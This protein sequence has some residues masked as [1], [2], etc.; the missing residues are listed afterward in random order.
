MTRA[1]AGFTLVELL[2]TLTVVAILSAIAWPG[3]GAI[4]HRAQR[5]D[6]RFALL[7]LQ[8]LQER[9]YATHFR[10][11]SAMGSTAANDTL[12]TSGTS[13]GGLYQLS[14]SVTEDGQGYVAIASADPDGRQRRD[15]DC[16][17]LSIDQTGRRRSADADGNWSATDLQRCWG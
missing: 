11:A 14:L 6:A 1:I 4:I 2:V 13:E 16:Q 7:R 15:R 3:Y 5:N 10:Y 17:Q 12:A 9:H 8:H